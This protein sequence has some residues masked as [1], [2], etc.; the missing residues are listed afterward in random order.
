MVNIALCLLLADRL[1]VAGLAL[2]SAASATVYALLLL[3]PL[4]RR[5]EKVLP[6]AVLA[7]LAKMALAA[8]VMG[9]CAWGLSRALAPLLP[10]GKAGEVLCLGLC[11][12]AG[13]ALYFLLTLALRVEETG[14]C[15]SLVKKTLK[16]G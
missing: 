6:G 14:L 5:E 11:A 16:R 1:S 2:A 9:V 7:D 12:L 13:V 8:A 3:L 15:V 4:Q 10:G